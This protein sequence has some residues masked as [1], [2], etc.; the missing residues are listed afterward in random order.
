M[1]SGNDKPVGFLARFLGGIA[2]FGAH[3]PRLALW[4]M[5][6]IGCAGVGI[7]VSDLKLHTSRSDLLSPKQTWTDYTNTFGGEG[8]RM[9]KVTVLAGM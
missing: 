4:L 8:R 5:V 1:A 9:P 6:F 3:R 2:G 7:T